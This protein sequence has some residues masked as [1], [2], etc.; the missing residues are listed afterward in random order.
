MEGW[1][2]R[3]TCPSK[4]RIIQGARSISIK[5]FL[6][7]LFFHIKLVRLIKTKI[8]EF[9]ILK[10]VFYYFRERFILD[11]KSNEYLTIKDNF[12]KTMKESYVNL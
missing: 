11:D 10:I 5:G 9:L 1:G 3:I 6:F 7:K 8:I 4:K 12:N 2:I